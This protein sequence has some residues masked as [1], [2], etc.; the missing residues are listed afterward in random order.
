MA[1]HVVGA[2]FLMGVRRA[3]R[4]QRFERVDE[5]APHVRVRIL[6]NGQRRRGMAD[7]HGEESRSGADLVEP[8]RK[9][10]GEFDEPLAL[11]LNG[12]A[13]ARLYHPRLR[14]ASRCARHRHRRRAAAP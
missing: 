13:V 6:L 8:A 11:R 3:L 7:K 5:I 2:L 9:S 14:I 1:R 10:A 12:E 4:R